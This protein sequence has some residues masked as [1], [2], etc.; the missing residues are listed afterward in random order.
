MHIITAKRV[1]EAKEKYPHCESALSGWLR[2]MKQNIFTNFADLKSSINS[3]DKVDD[4]YVFDI[5]G[6]K[7]RLI[8][9]I[10]FGRGKVFIKQILAHEEYDEGKWKH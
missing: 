3:V 8:A 5:G 9:S 2:I 10:K 4:L 1:Q 6:N 7:L